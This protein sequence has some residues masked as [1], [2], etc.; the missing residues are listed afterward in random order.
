MDD[1]LYSMEWVLPLRSD[2][3]TPIAEVFT[4][5][6]YTPFFLIFLP[7]GYWLWDRSIFTR[8]TVLVTI[9]A[10]LNG[11]FKDFWQD[12]RPGGDIQLDGRVTGEP[13]RPS[14]HAQVAVAMW[15]WLAHEISRPWAWVVAIVLAVGVSLSRIYLGV[16]DVDDVLTGTALALITLVVFAWLVRPN[17]PG[18]SQLRASPVAQLALIVALIP[19]IWAVW[20]AAAQAADRAIHSGPAPTLTV[21][22][23]L[24]GW[25]AGAALDARLCPARGPRPQWWQQIIIAVS[26]IVVL[27]ALRSLIEWGG[28]VA[29][30]SEMVT[31][32]AGGFILGF[33]MTC[34]APMA[35]RAVRLM[36]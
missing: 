22:F 14:G 35:F 13:G 34:L 15:L 23:L 36:R 10:V 20:P 1:L 28:E 12:P 6:G 27:F 24:G 19:V 5:L 31:A 7:I 8:L 17:T 18:I 21:M 9:T 32:F 2:W 11:W 29:G 30:L 33:Y 16:H 26:G 3:A 25:I 4:W